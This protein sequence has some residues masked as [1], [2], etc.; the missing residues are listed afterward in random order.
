LL[1]RLLDELLDLDPAEQ[2]RRLATLQSRYPRLSVWL[3]RL[4]EASQRT[5]P[6]LL[7]AVVRTAQRATGSADQALV[8]EPGTRL[9]SWRIVGSAGRGG[10]G[11]VYRAER[12]DGAFEM[13]A[14]IKLIGSH[15]PGLAERLIQE[16]RLLARLNHPGIS[17]LIDGGVTEAG[18]AY[19]VMEW[20][21]GEDL[22]ETVLDALDPLKTF[23]EIA[24][25]LTH[26]HQRMVVHG[27]IKPGNVRITPRGRARLLDFGVARLL[28]DE[29]ID[30]D[31]SVRA[32]TPAFA[33][34]ELLLGQPA[35]AQSDVWALGALLNWLLTARRPAGDGS[36]PDG[37]GIEHP[38]APDLAAVI[39]KACADDASERYPSVAA[40][41]DEIRRIRDH[42]PV[43]AR[44]AGPLRRLQFWSGRN[45][46]G[47]A[48]ALALTVGAV[49]AASLLAWQSQVVKAERDLARVE[50]TRWE[51][52]REQLV[53]LFRV[54]A[55]DAEGE[56]LGA[57]ELLDGSVAR[58]DDLMAGD[59]QGRDY[60]ETML[61][62]LY[63]ALQDYQS[64]ANVLRRFVDSDDGLAAPILRSDA[65]G[66]L[67]LAEGH[68]GNH[69]RA[70]ALVDEAIRMVSGLPGDYR[71]RLSE[72]YATRGSALRGMGD[73]TAAI[74]ALERGVALAIEADPRPNR[75]LAMA[76]NNLGV[77][78]N[79][80][81]R[82]D[83][84]RQALEDSLAQ[85]RALGLGESS[86]ALT[87][88]GNLAAIYYRQGDLGRAESAYAEA[89]ELRRRQFGDSAALAAAM[90]NYGQVLMI[91]YRL[92]AAG[93]QLEQARDMMARF[94]G[95]GS[96][97]FALM[98]RSLG[99]LALTAD[100]LD[101]ASEL[102]NRAETILLDT[103]G[104][105]HLFTVLVSAQLAM[106]QARRDPEAGV[107]WLDEVISRMAEVGDPAETH[108]ATTLC[109]K[110]VTLLDLDRID[111]AR[112]AAETCL[113]IRRARLHEGHWEIRKAEALIA[114]ADYQRGD[115]GLRPVLAGHIEA[116]AETYGAGH[117]RLIWLEDQLLH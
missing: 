73:W 104:P 1:D 37:S 17:R 82:I 3:S 7:E 81:G 44:P 36:G 47:A 74:E 114:L 93:D 107:V 52:M 26:A 2:A 20:V 42:H 76:Y 79:H 109:E 22:S 103:V 96:P 12:A 71:R 14:A 23:I 85:W 46:V 61:G 80:A 9:G 88:L 38:R 84:A 97:H 18:Q 90:N 33:A 35:T 86:D 64:A 32:L 60:I 111:S 59:D 6:H 62:S 70:L 98:L 10:M 102:L 69:E 58:L 65:Y 43:Q 21:P 53:T 13:Q 29:T 30:E 89:I 56:E 68:L 57:R 75:T 63:V 116:L 11:V 50:V 113:A 24:D 72:L 92:A 112:A 48:L 101:R 19:L 110:A 108:R 27:D 54:V 8:L 91:R 41:A 5:A 39:S 106:T 99:M 87:V 117:P 95:S 31:E 78:L 115:D 66:N 45:P 94:N 100:D 77:N 49:A 25:A 105:D 51:I 16:R 34:P 4:V 40:L 55:E 67:A 83:E 15:H 28:A